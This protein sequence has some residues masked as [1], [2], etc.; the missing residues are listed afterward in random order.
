MHLQWITIFLLVSCW[1]EP[2]KET[3][4][5]WE[6]SSL[7]STLIHGD[8]EIESETVIERRLSRRKR[9]TGTS[10][11]TVDIE[12][13]FPDA[14]FANQIKQFI[15]K[16]LTLPIALGN[17][18][19][20][21]SSISVT[22][23]CNQTGSS[24]HCSCESGYMFPEAVCASYITC[25]GSNASSC[26]CING[27]TIPTQ[28]CHPKPVSINLS[29]RILE[30]FTADFKDPTSDKYKQYKA[31]L[32]SLFTNAYKTLTGFKSATIK[33]FRPG[34]LVADYTVVTEPVSTS[35]ITTANTNLLN[36]LKLANYSVD[37]KITTIVIDKSSIR[38]S[39]INIF[40]KDTLVLTCIVNISA[41]SSI[42]WY[43][44]GTEEIGNTSYT[45]R[46]V[47][48]TI[49]SI[50][51]I[52]RVSLNNT[53]TYR[54]TF[55]D[56]LYT[57]QAEKSIVVQPLEM[58]VLNTNIA[59]NNTVIPVIKCCTQGIS[60]DFDM[61]C[62]VKSGISGIVRN[63][64]PCITYQVATNNTNCTSFNNGNYDCT[65]FTMN[66]AN[67][68]RNVKVVYQATYEVSVSSNA[69]IV[70]EG[71]ELTMRC[72]CTATAVRNITWFLQ[73][74]IL[75][76]YYK[77]DL[78]TC[79]STLTIPKNVTTLAWNGTFT[80]S[81]E[82]VSNGILSA[83]KEIRIARLIR[84]S[85][86]ITSPVALNF[87]CNQMI[88]FYCCISSMTA[89][90]GA[91]LEIYTKLGKLYTS[92]MDISGQ[93]FRTSNTPT[94][95]NN[96]ECLDFKAR[97]NI[98]NTI[99]DTVTSE[100]M[101][102]TYVKAPKCTN[103]YIG[104]INS[105]TTISCQDKDQ[106]L[107]G[108]I[109]Y[110]CT[111]GQWIE[112]TSNCVSAAL[113]DIKNQLETLTSPMA[114][115]EVPLVLGNLSATVISD[116]KN[117]TA[118]EYDI[119]L[120]VDLLQTVEGALEI[121][122]TPVMENFLLTVNIVVDNT[123]TW[124]RVPVQEQSNLLLS[125]ERFAKK[126]SISGQVNIANN[127]NVQLFGNIISNLTDYKAD[128]NFSQSHN[129]T[130]NVLINKTALSSFSP[131]ATIVSIAYA[132]LKD[133]LKA[134]NN[135]SIHGIINGCVMTTIVRGNYS[136]FPIVMDFKKND[137]ELNKTACVFWNF[138][139]QNWDGTGCRSEFNNDSSMVTC[140]CDHLTSFSILMSSEYNPIPEEEKIL[141]YI[142]YFGLGISIL[143]LVICIIIEAIVWKS[144]TKNKTSYMRHVCIMNIA[145]T[146]LMADIWFIVGIS[147]S[148]S[149]KVDAC[150]AA[151]FFTH[152]FYLCTF[153]WMLTMGLILFYRLM[154]V[155][156]DL[157]KTVMMGISFFLGYGCPI[158]ISVITVAVTQPSKIY[159]ASNA[160]WLNMKESSAFL[161][162]VIP[163]LSILLVNFITL[164][165]V[166]IKVLRPSVGDKPK[167]DEKSSLNHIAKCI[168]IL[169]PLLGLTWGLGIG[170]MFINTIAM[171]G[172]FSALNSLQGLFILLFGCLMD[173]KVRDALFSRFSVS[174]WSSQ[175]TK[176]SNLSSADPVFSKG[177]INLFS[178]K[179]VYNISSAQASSS[180]EMSNSYS[181]LT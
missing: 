119:K 27:S 71:R 95:G 96:G 82:T 148:A 123:T 129:L 38:V 167:K 84:T 174:R 42:S 147:M 99:G 77:N 128:F 157:S 25:P 49:Q 2:S 28:Y 19:T 11:Y 118:S 159:T 10:E 126:L 74:N 98:T 90:S 43:L 170:T 14:S 32:E 121:V 173:K 160:C 16:N 8:H 26:D 3:M 92:V 62:A 60:M 166:I 141:T 83:I 165:V 66:G 181:L 22:T 54:C 140:V 115:D 177:V 162:F 41:Y 51:I 110:T 37:P 9:D 7:L 107:T 58:N 21:I 89:Y 73:N 79:T 124:Q 176:T 104:D 116:K 47:D 35:A 18:D 122:E 45:T 179:G 94:P 131:N 153:F 175:Q 68:T 135:S 136:N 63:N 70:S 169:T 151:T 30:E 108:T 44:N 31:N 150:V 13:S 76:N 145:V 164:F 130:G 81:V 87:Q 23:A 127:S 39:P 100:Y 112:T 53:G 80:C 93:C 24:V 125:V 109:N 34:S 154:C 29:L 78:T 91:V 75:S 101:D 113:N 46:P 120:V 158:I 142:S 143:S 168:L 134:G 106:S 138:T 1:T 17:N 155:F 6:L 72:N 146:L 85:Q 102:L 5:S 180:S 163:A 50:L 69:D 48:S 86:I 88:N 117:I 137:T 67:E 40:N 56:N 161:A 59:C 171:H 61:T 152:V 156:H 97:C 133:I 65:C 114:K 15:A 103:P 172:I 144:V 20:E 12:I 64:T 132:T 36:S 105:I 55:D 139:I 178:K 52:N 111:G 57:Y 4:G 149:G 33:G